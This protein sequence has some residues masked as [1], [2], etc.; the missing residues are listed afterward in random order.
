MSKASEWA[1]REPKNLA[2]PQMGSP[3]AVSV[4]LVTEKGVPGMRIDNL[5]PFNKRQSKR[6]ASWILDTF[7]ES[8]GTEPKG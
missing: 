2:L 1:K 3:C 8:E 7:E 4:F 5:G 6:L